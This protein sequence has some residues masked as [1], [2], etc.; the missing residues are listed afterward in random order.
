M[1]EMISRDPEVGFACATAVAAPAVLVG[2]AGLAS[3]V[4]GGGFLALVIGLY[5]FIFA[6]IVAA[7]HVLLLGLPAYLLLRRI[8]EPGWLLCG[9]CGLALG[10]APYFLIDVAGGTDPG[11]ALPVALFLG[12]MGLIAGLSFRWKLYPTVGGG[13]SSDL[14]EAP[15]D[16]ENAS[17]KQ[18]LA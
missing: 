3:M 12:A 8:A 16:A 15:D 13:A 17:S 5:G 1:T 7:A 2:M 9:T 11:N 6:F 18:D 4:V 14:V 10:A